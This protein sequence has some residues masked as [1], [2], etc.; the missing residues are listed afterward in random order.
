MIHLLFLSCVRLNVDNVFKVLKKIDKDWQWVAKEVLGISSSKCQL[1]QQQSSS[2]D[3]SL[4]QSIL[5]FIKKY[6]DAS[7]RIL[8]LTLDDEN[9]GALADDIRNFAEPLLGKGCM[10]VHWH[11]H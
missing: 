11:I 5:F 7:W 3:E 1:I 9:Y 6:V 10:D 8:I 4:K 2:P